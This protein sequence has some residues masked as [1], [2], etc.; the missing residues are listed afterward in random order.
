MCILG[1]GHQSYTNDQYFLSFKKSHYQVYI[2]QSIYISIFKMYDINIFFFYLNLLFGH[3]Q[4]YI[5]QG[6]GQLSSRDE[7]VAILQSTNIQSKSEISK[8]ILANDISHHVKNP[9][10]LSNIVVFT[11]LIILPGEWGGCHNF[12]DHLLK[13]LNWWWYLIF[14]YNSWF[15]MMP[16][17]E[18]W[19]LVTFGD[20]LW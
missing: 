16:I 8:W 20:I 1:L 6:M 4:P 2:S 3:I 14:S 7:T 18:W 5:L 11:E 12:L 19:T 9:K 10:R 17:C 15:F 13:E